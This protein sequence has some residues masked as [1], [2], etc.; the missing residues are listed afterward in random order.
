MEEI[1]DALLLSGGI[2]SIAIAYW[3]RPKFAITIDYGQR[4]AEKE[5]AVARYIAEKLCINHRVI[6]ANVG[7]LGIGLLAGQEQL[8][9]APTPEWW[10][11]R[12]QFLITLAAMFAAKHGVKRILIGTVSSDAQ[13]ADGTENFLTACGGLLA[14]Q[15]GGIEL[16]APARTKTSIELVRESGIPT[17][18]LAAAHSCHCGNVACGCCRG[19]QKHSDVFA[20]V[21]LLPQP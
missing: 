4:T 13:C 12:N 16:H 10:P 6:R 18:L 14:L 3:M 15:E 2:D 11:F 19:C 5:I 20:S 1:K 8:E 9:S 21:G 17:S 7:E